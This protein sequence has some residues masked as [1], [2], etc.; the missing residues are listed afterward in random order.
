MPDFL[1][2]GCL[3]KPFVSYLIKE[4]AGF[5]NLRIYQMSEGKK[6]ACRT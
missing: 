2:A 1:V 3:I 4:R 6:T 5:V